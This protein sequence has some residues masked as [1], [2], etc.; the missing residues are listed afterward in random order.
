M[1]T[2]AAYHAQ[3]FFLFQMSINLI[4]THIMRP[5]SQLILFFSFFEKPRLNKD[6]FAVQRSFI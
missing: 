1:I 4:K 3:L 5:F 2:N 6:M